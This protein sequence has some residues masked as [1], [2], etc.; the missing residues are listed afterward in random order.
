MND[1]IE[2]KTKAGAIDYLTKQLNVLVVAYDKQM[3][4]E[5]FE[6]MV[7]IV[8]NGL[9]KYDSLDKKDFDNVFDDIITSYTKYRTF[10]AS[11]YLSAFRE[12]RVR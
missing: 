9:C 8:I 10:N 1:L 5:R 3:E 11:V 2:E 4:L 7:K 12:R 6:K